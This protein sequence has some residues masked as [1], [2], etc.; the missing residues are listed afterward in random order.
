MKRLNS[1]LNKQR[2]LSIVE[3]MI[4]L[5]LSLVVMLVTTS[6]YVNNKQTY[7]F[8]DANSLLQENGRFGIYFLRESALQAGYPKNITTVEAFPS[9]AADRPTEGGVVDG[10]PVPDTF[11]VTYWGQRDCLG[12]APTT[13]TLTASNDRLI[14]D[15]F[16]IGDPDGDGVVGLVCDGNGENGAPVPALPLVD[17]IQ[18]MQVEYGVDT[19]AGVP[20]DRDGIA[21]TYVTATEVQNGVLF[22]GPEWDRVVS[23]RISLLVNANTAVMDENTNVNFRMLNHAPFAINDRIPRRVF[24]T[25]IPLRNR[26]KIIF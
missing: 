18:N 17:G 26:N 16:S 4:A 6:V 25:T 21:D 19:D 8:I 24:T 2:G 5:V 22:A 3:L 1:T 10:V 13:A 23:M 20:D 11:S 12:N 7:R 15:T 14:Q 9:A